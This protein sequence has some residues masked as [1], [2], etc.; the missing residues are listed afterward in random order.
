MIK[1]KMQEEIR[2]LMDGQDVYERASQFL[3]W[4]FSKH[5]PNAQ[6]FPNWTKLGDQFWY[7]RQTTTGHGF[8]LID[9]SAKARTALFDHERLAE[10]LN[11]LVAAAGEPVTLAPHRL[12]LQAIEFDSESNTLRFSVHGKKI[13]CCLETYECQ[14]LVRESSGLAESLSP[15]GKKVAFVRDHNLFVRQLETGVETA[16]TTD[17]E[18]YCAYGGYCDHFGTTSRIFGISLP[19]AVSWSPDSQFVLSQR[20]DQRLVKELAL[21]QSAPSDNSTRPKLH[22]YRMAMPGDQY[23]PEVHL[24]VANANT[25]ALIESRRKPVP[26]GASGLVDSGYAWWGAESTKVYFIETQRGAHALTFVQWDVMSGACREVYSETSDHA[27]FPAP[28]MAILPLV[29]CLEGS[30]EFIWFSQ[31][32]GWGHLYLHDLKTGECKNAITAGEFVVQ[33]VHYVDEAARTLYFSA[34][35]REDGQNPYFRHVYRIGF[36]GSGLTRLTEESAHHSVFDAPPPFIAMLADLHPRISGW[37]PSGKYFID[38]WSRVDLAPTIAVRCAQTGAVV[39]SLE[40][41]DLSG[42]ER[43]G[44]CCPESFSV[45]AA[46]NE[47]ALYGVLFKPSD[48]DPS[49]KYPVILNI[50]AGPQIALLPRGFMGPLATSCPGTLMSLAELGAIVVYIEPRGTPFRSRAFQNYSYG[51]LQNGGGLEDQIA[52]LH[53]LA[54]RYPWIDL[55]RVGITG[56]SGGGYASCRGILKYPDFFRVAVSSA[57]NHDQ[58][59][60][61]ADWAETFQGLPSKAHYDDLSNAELAENLEGKLLLIQGE[62][63]SNVHPSQTLRL[64][65]ALVKAD[66]RFDFLLIPNATHFNPNTPFFIRRVWDYFYEHLIGGVPPTDFRIAPADAPMQPIFGQ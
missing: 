7:R 8:V 6:I 32:S 1:Q 49:K 12:P 62:L 51:N 30:D 56:H 3:P 16:L 34:G 4:N 24:V 27:L 38:A 11:G 41:S 65:D 61:I 29:R 5:V 28:T 44:W 52:A 43:L 42:L 21:I 48:F 13:L 36:D 63:D 64:V 47:T 20:I 19:P 40:T 58:N 50:Y 39:M 2:M 60:Y 57:G 31:E 18:Q 53:Q 17:G 14:M 35:G 25:G 10:A 26:G 23:A 66:K 15:D 37:S 22:T 55:D 46:D 33:S 54:E 9:P 59:L 45:S